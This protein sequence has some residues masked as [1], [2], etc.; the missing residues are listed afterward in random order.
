M[1]DRRLPRDSTSGSI[2]RALRHTLPRGLD[3]ASATSERSLPP[4]A[5]GATLPAGAGA[6]GAGSSLIFSANLK[7]R[8]SKLGSLTKIFGGKSSSRDKGSLRGVLAAH[9]CIN[10]Y[11]EER[12]STE[13][14]FQIYF[15]NEDILFPSGYIYFS[16]W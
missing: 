7:K 13:S 8:G 5:H 15:F 1:P 4:M 10:I 3:G 11:K 12:L 6:S 16:Q 2:E 14:H 9:S